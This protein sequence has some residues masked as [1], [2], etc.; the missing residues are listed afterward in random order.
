VQMPQRGTATFNGMMVGN[1]QNGANAYVAAGSYGSVW[2]FGA[3][4]GTFTASFDGTNYAGAG[5]A[6][7][8]SGGASFSGAFGGG[9]R[10]GQFTGSFFGPAAQ[11]QGGSFTIGNNLTSYKASGIFAGQQVG[12]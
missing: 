6:N 9:G 2:N 10:A 12:R 7:I 3:R 8:G 1:V 5:V 4:A 11:N